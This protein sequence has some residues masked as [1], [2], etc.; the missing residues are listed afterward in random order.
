[1]NHVV[2]TQ[3]MHEADIRP[4]TLLSEFKRLSVQ[5]AKRFFGDPATLVEV[6][7]PSSEDGASTFA[8]EKDG[9]RYMQAAECGSLYVSPRP[10]KDALADY[11]RNSRA[12]AYRVEHYAKETAE[13]RRLHLLRSHANWMGRL[14]DEHGNAAA[15]SYVDIGTNSPA[16]FD[17]VRRLGLFDQLYSLNPL[18]GLESECKAHGVTVIHE[19]IRDAGAVTAFQQLESQFS[20]LDLVKTACDMLAVGGLFFMTT[21]T[22]SGFDLQMLWD[23]TP[24]IFVPEH[25]NLLSIEGMKRLIA[26]AGLHTVELSTPGQLDVELVAH[27]ARNDAGIHLPRFI[28]YLLDERDD[29]AHDDFQEFL[30]KHRLSSH[31]R[32]AAVRRE[33]ASL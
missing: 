13:A 7:P 15:K 17:E 30:Q 6:P 9:F 24:Y 31:V 27:A 10:T 23:K 14:Y 16:I 11:Y 4:P 32:V 29:L 26:R 3:E 2:V 5:D 25:L 19:P 8:F 1:M 28:Q 21:R 12:S 20:P 33:G 18:P 22:I